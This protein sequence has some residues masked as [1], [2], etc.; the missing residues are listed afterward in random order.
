AKD[1]AQL[2]NSKAN[3][4]RSQQLLKE[5][6]ISQQQYDV[7]IA[8]EGANAASVDADRAAIDNEQVQLSYTKIYSPLDGRT[9]S[10]LANEG[11][12]IKANA[13][14][15][16]VTI[17]QI[18]PIYVQFAIPEKD[19]AAVKRYSGGSALKVKA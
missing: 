2:E 4:T 10:L 11:N 1:Q 8:D 16:M 18:N 5:G 3:A 17:N 15:S 14:T 9:G 13:D 12:L 6:V 19:L 7:A